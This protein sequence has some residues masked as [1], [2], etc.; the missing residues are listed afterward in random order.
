MVKRSLEM[1][2]HWT[3]GH[4]SIPEYD[5]KTTFGIIPDDT[6]ET[7]SSDEGSR[8]RSRKVT[9]LAET[10]VCIIPVHYTSS[11]SG[12]TVYEDFDNHIN[13]KVYKKLTDLHY[14]EWKCVPRDGTFRAMYN[15]SKHGDSLV[16]VVAE[17]TLTG[18]ALWST[19]N[20]LLLIVHLDG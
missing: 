14:C 9:E 1:N 5:D 2:H 6:C 18:M 20:S 10:K 19:G 16:R 11:V 4:R 17:T 15:T 12:L 8:P 7:H 13:V 3:S